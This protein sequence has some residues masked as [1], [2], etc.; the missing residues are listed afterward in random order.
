MEVIDIFRYNVDIGFHM[1]LL[2]EGVDT[3]CELLEIQIEP[4]Y[5][6]MGLGWQ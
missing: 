3:N 2:G 4:N 5:E 6:I 1:A